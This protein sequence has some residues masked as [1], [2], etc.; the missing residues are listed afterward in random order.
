MTPIRNYLGS[1]S[2]HPSN[3]QIRE[4]RVHLWHFLCKTNPIL[5][6]FSASSLL[7][8][9]VL[10]RAYAKNYNFVETQKQ[11]QFKPNQTQNKPNSKPTCLG[12][13]QKRRIS[14]NPRKPAGNW[15]IYG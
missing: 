3:H 9:L 6:P 14:R 5:G 2:K 8:S 15:S 10:L 7:L 12:E 4:I 1:R 11:S 13:A